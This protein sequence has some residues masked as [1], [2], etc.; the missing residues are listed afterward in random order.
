[1]RSNEKQQ[2]CRSFSKDN[3]NIFNFLNKWAVWQVRCEKVIVQTAFFCNNYSLLKTVEWQIP[4]TMLRYWKYGCIIVKYKLIQIN[5]VN[6]CSN[7][8]DDTDVFGIFVWWLIYQHSTLTSDYWLMITPRNLAVDTLSIFM[9]S[10]L[11]VS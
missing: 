6:F 10:I 5:G 2:A 1:M 4:H 3:G 11:K 7:V 9:L 8:A